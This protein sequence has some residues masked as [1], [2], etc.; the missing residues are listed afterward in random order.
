MLSIYPELKSK[1]K[2]TFLFYSILLY[3]QFI[4]DFQFIAVVFC[5]LN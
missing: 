2:T 5:H 3:R 4:Y 1:K